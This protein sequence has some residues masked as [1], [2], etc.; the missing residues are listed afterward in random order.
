MSLYSRYRI[1]TFA[2]TLICS[3]TFLTSALRAQGLGNSPYSSLGMGEF[4]GESFSDNTGMGQSGVSTSSGFQVNNL[5]PALLVRN[6]FTTL[7]IGLIGQYKDMVSG[8]KNQ[9][10]SGGNLGYVS[11][12]FPV[13]PKWALG[14]N[15]KPYTFVDYENTFTRQVPGTPA[16][17]HYNT[18]GKGGINKASLTNSFQIGKYLSLGLESSYFFGNVRKASEVILPESN[19]V[20]LDNDYLVSLNER[21]TYSDISFRGG[22]ALRIP[23]KKNNKL[24]L[25]LGGA[26]SLS[27]SINANQTTSF[28]VSQ[29]SFNI[30]DPDTL[31][32]N[33]GSGLKTP[34]QFQVGASLEW[35]FKLIISAD[36]NRQSW[37]KYRSVAGTN[38]GLKDIGRVNVGLEYLPRF[39]SLNYF[40]LV[41]YRIGFSHGKTPYSVNNRDVND[42]NV[43]LGFTFPMGRGYQNFLSI[44][45][46][47]GQRG[48]TG[49]GMIRERYGRAVLGITLLERW[50]VKQ[51]ID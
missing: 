46:V 12:S 25:N 34:E 40:D 3:C 43:S 15:L 20:N 51:K 6:R 36:Y 17:V 45:I 31:V 30:V 11:L 33:A 5:N 48:N 22:V 19:V 27:K 32:N 38:E 42:T 37:S 13:G 4:Y 16:I 14:V 41:R 50:F 1:L 10:N 24:N 44:A 9:R 26:Y 29:S 35:P 8:N 47:A 18:T 21:T 23:I 49:N 39:T 2:I 7:D 28:E